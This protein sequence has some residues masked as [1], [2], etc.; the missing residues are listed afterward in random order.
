MGLMLDQFL[1]GIRHVTVT[2]LAYSLVV[3]YSSVSVGFVLGPCFVVW[4]SLSFCFID[5]AAEEE[6]S[7]CFTVMP[8]K[9]DSDV[10]FVY[11]CKV[12]IN[13]YTSLA[14]TRIDRSLVY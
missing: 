3:V 9:I 10:I 13:K 14:L 1:W 5:H 11:N 4:F 8:T 7:G 12:N 2:F 6:I